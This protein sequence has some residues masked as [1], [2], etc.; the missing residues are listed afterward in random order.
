[1]TVM[2]SQRPL[3]IELTNCSYSAND[4]YVEGPNINGCQ[5]FDRVNGNDRIAVWTPINFPDDR[6]YVFEA[7]KTC[8]DNSSVVN[9]FCITNLVSDNCE[10]I[11]SHGSAN[12]NDCIVSVLE[13]DPCFD[14]L[15]INNQVIPDNTYQSF[16]SI[17]SNGTVPANGEVMFKSNKIELNADFE[18]VKPAIFEALIEPDDCI[19]NLCPPIEDAP[20]FEQAIADLSISGDGNCMAAIQIPFQIS[21]RFPDRLT[22][23]V[24]IDNNSSTLSISLDNI[25]GS[26]ANYTVIGSVPFG[27]NELILNVSDTNCNLSAS[28]TFEVTVSDPGV[29]TNFTCRWLTKEIGPSGTVPILSSEI[30]SQQFDCYPSAT[31]IISA[32]STDRTDTEKILTCDDLG[33]QQVTVFTWYV[34]DNDNDGVLDTVY[35]RACI[36]FHRA[37]D[38]GGFCD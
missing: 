2:Y 6:E 30:V 12:C 10:I 28:M 23:S 31:E 19:E 5:C 17:I 13:R 9:N 37:I 27:T 15:L 25:N 38:P 35:N 14:I 36:T 1:M 21:Y 4:V 26:T 33:D 20:T 24:D 18:V 22:A 8:A 34:S 3:K 32:F 7:G 29:L 16:G 11:D